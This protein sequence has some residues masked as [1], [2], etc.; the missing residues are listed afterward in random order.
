MTNHHFHRALEYPEAIKIRNDTAPLLD[1]F[2]TSPEVRLFCIYG[3]G[4]ETLEKLRYD[5]EETFP[6]HPSFGYGDGDGTVGRRS[7]ELCHRYAEL[8][9]QNVTTLKIDK[10]D[11]SGILSNDKALNFIAK[12][13]VDAAS[14]RTEINP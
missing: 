8:Q 4:V 5:D 11:H 14:D 7:L 9:S 1:K 6:D 3:V 10:V 13:V 2:S 12:I